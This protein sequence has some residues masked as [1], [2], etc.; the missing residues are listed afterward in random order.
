MSRIAAGHA[1]AAETGSPG[2]TQVM[3][4]TGALALIVMAVHAAWALAVVRRG[5]EPELVGF[6]RFSLWVWALWL[7]P[8]VTGMVGS[9][10][11]GS[12]TQLA[13]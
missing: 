8:Y 11:G 6:H 2:L 4:V 13:G 3:A 12:G 5:R 9:M 1:G 10:S 7:V